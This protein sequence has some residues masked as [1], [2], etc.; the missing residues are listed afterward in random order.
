M[1]FGVNSSPK[2]LNKKTLIVIIKA[3]LKVQ[4]HLRVVGGGNVAIL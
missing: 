3:P 4:L 2:G 1:G